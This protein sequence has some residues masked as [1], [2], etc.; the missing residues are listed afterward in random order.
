MKLVYGHSSMQAEGEEE[1]EKKRYYHI[2]CS[3]TE[4]Q[5]RHAVPRIASVVNIKHILCNERH[6]ADQ[7]LWRW[8]GFMDNYCNCDCSCRLK[9]TAVSE[10]DPLTCW[11][12]L[13]MTMKQKYLLAGLRSQPKPLQ[14]L[15]LWC[16][17]NK[18]Q[19]ISDCSLIHVER[20]GL[21]KSA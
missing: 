14:S 3:N 20:A 9:T 10:Q 19:C 17:R 13:L 7:H 8:R 5:I 15:Y 4:M 16:R 6:N 12:K 11:N 21:I 1:G 18:R 2:P